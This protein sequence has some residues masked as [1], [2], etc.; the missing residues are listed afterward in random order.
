MCSVRDGPR[1]Q[2]SML[3][4][5]P[6]IHKVLAYVPSGWCSM[7]WFLLQHSLLVLLEWSAIPCPTPSSRS[8]RSLYVRLHHGR[9]PLPCILSVCQRHPRPGRR[10]YWTQCTKFVPSVNVVIDCLGG[11]V[12]E[13]VCRTC[14]FVCACMFWWSCLGATSLGLHAVRP[15]AVCHRSVVFYGWLLSVAV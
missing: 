7:C 12:M 13:S 6:S 4:E 15:L 1:S 9:R 14:P 8:P 3:P 10:A 2:S 11:E 5:T